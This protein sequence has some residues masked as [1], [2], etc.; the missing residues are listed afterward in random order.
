MRR[1]FKAMLCPI[2]IG[3][4]F[5]EVLCG[6]HLNCTV[7]LIDEGSFGGKAGENFGNLSYPSILSIHNNKVYAFFLKNAIKK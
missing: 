4:P 1:Y 3:H 7:R 6:N 2:A 5:C